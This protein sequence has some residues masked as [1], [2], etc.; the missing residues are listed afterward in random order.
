MP[1]HTPTATDTQHGLIPYLAGGWV[2]RDTTSPGFLPRWIGSH[3]RG[4][5]KQG[6]ARERYKQ[7]EETTDDTIKHEIFAA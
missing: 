5:A 7:A 4:I 3:S 6:I 2:S 1:T